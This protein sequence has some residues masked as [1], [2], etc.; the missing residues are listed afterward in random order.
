M[1][2][3]KKPFLV[4]TIFFRTI[5]KKLKKAGLELETLIFLAHEARF[6]LGCTVK[7]FYNVLH[8]LV[9][10]LQVHTIQG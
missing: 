3:E 9:G 5:R 1:T 7:H 2:S 4:S 10:H 8:L 6:A